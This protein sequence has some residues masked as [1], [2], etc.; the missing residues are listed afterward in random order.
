MSD[1]NFT[2]IYNPY[3]G[4]SLPPV[5]KKNTDS[6]KNQ[7][8]SNQLT[9]DQLLEQELNGGQLIFSK[10]A[11]QRVESRQVTMTP[12]LMTEL[13]EAVLQAKSKGIQDALIVTDDASFVVNVSVNTV[14]TTLNHNESKHRVFTNIDGTVII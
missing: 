9:F 13:N 7:T 2:R 14:V 6:I 1:S 11:Q 4:T 12:Q 3:I 5:Q 8:T 10:H